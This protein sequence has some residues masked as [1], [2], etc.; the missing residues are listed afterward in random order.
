MLELGNSGSV[1]ELANVSGSGLLQLCLEEVRLDQTLLHLLLEAL[2]ASTLPLIDP[3]VGNLHLARAE[4]ADGLGPVID[5]LHSLLNVFQVSLC[6]QLGGPLDS[7]RR[8]HWAFLRR[9]GQRFA[10]V[11]LRLQVLAVVREQDGAFLG[12]LVLRRHLGLLGYHVTQEGLI[13]AAEL[14]SNLAAPNSGPDRGRRLLIQVDVAAGVDRG[15]FH[16]LFDAG[17]GLHLMI[18]VLG[19]PAQIPSS[20][21]SV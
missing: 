9:G 2:Q 15:K 8:P 14:A 16:L 18:S 4:F 1:F 21:H 11:I 3:L 19:S 17:T 10:V 5:L 7:L 13:E 6:G 20:F 12:C